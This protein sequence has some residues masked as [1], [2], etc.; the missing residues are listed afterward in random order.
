MGN[1][2]QSKY[3]RPEHFKGEKFFESPNQKAALPHPKSIC[4]GSVIVHYVPQK[5]AL[6]APYN[7]YSHP[8]E[9]WIHN[10]REAKALAEKINAI[11]T[12][13]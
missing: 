11:L 1:Q 8:S 4:I 3:A 9:Q 12:K 2:Y 7:R 13:A 5:D 10:K 6:A